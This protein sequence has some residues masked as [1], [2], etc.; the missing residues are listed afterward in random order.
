MLKSNLCTG[1]GRSV[2]CQ[3][4]PSE[5]DPDRCDLKPEPDGN[6]SH[7]TNSTQNWFLRPTGVVLA[8]TRH[9]HH[10]VRCCDRKSQ[11]EAL[12]YSGRTAKTSIEWSFEGVEI[13]FGFDCV[14]ADLEGLGE[15]QKHASHNGHSISFCKTPC[16]PPLKA[17]KGPRSSQTRKSGLAHLGVQL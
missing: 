6:A 13:Y 8:L 2:S 1:D 15:I 7:K 5:L 4:I 17:E 10:Q 12:K 3:T 14:L 9:Q 11:D 16:C